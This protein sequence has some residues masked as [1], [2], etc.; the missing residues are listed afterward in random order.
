MWTILVAYRAR[1]RCTCKLL[2]QGTSTVAAQ[3]QSTL[4][5]IEHCTT[6]QTPQQCLSWFLRLKVQ[7]NDLQGE[8]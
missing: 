3:L 2:V 6:A 1:V 4:L 8:S 5:I 7:G